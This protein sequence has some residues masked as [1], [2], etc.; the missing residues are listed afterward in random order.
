[1]TRRAARGRARRTRP[2]AS[3]AT[4]SPSPDR[5]SRRRR[6]RRAQ[7]ADRARRTCRRIV[8]TRTSSAVVGPFNSNVAPRRSR[9]RNEAGLL[10]CSPANTRHR[11]DQGRLGR[12]DLPPDNP[13]RASTTSASPRPMTYP[14][15]ARRRV[16]LQQPRRLRNIFVLDDQT[17]LRRR[18]SRTRSRRS[19]RRSAAPSPRDRATTPDTTGLHRRSLTEAA[20]TPMASTSVA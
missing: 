1:M 15:P 10:Q 5:R 2:A 6:Q 8:A 14:G 4:T 11:P 16:R 18:A 3:A 13:G 17:A 7:S 9:S 20:R 12:P 19:S